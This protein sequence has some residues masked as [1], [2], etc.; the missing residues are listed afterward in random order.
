[1][2]IYQCFST[3]LSLKNIYNSFL[4]LIFVEYLVSTEPMTLH[5]LY[6]QVF[7]LF[8]DNL[9]LYILG[10]KRKKKCIHIVKEINLQYQTILK[11]K[12]HW[13]IKF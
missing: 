10:T 1:M 13:Y 11:I 4:V 9:L 2:H 8:F 7:S 6:L 5:G 12:E 3:I